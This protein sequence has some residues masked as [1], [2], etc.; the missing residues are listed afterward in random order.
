[1]NGVRL[2]IAASGPAAEPVME[3]RFSSRDYGAKAPSVSV[4]WAVRA[5][6]P[7]TAQFML[8]PVC[9]NEDPGER[10]ERGQARLPDLEVD[11]IEC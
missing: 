7:L 2:L 11:Q 5:A 6:M 8:V 9:A 3:S 1:M 4:C 10:L